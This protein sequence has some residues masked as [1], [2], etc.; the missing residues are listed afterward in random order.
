MPGNGRS[1]CQRHGNRSKEILKE[2][3]Q[4]KSPGWRGII[5]QQEGEE[6]LWRSMSGEMIW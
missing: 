4:R 2:I 1:S 3:V 5:V 6:E